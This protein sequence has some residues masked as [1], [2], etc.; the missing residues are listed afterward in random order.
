M[1]DEHKTM[2]EPRH[3]LVAF[4]AFELEALAVCNPMGW[5]KTPGLTGPERQAV[6]R[7]V[8]KLK[9]ANLRAQTSLIVDGDCTTP[10]GEVRSVDGANAV[11]NQSYLSD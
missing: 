10:L 5:A 2:D 4:T 8:N 1:S 7:V 3:H 9:A 6:Q 11:R